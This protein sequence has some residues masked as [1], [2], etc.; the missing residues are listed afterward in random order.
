MPRTAKKVDDLAEDGEH[1]M[2]ALSSVLEI[3][4]EKGVVTW[5]DV[6]E[7][8]TTGEWSRLIEEGLL[9][10]ADGEGFVVDD[11]DGVREAMEDADPASTDDGGV[12]WT[13]YDKGA[14]GIVMMLFVGYVFPE[15][16]AVIGGTIDIAFGPLENM[17]PF[18]LVIMMLALLTGLFSSIMQDNLMDANNMG[19]YKEKSEELKERRKKAK[20]RGD[21]EALEEIQQE[22]MEMMT[23]NVG[24]FTAQ[25]RPMVWIML[26]TIPVFLWLY[27]M[28]LDVGI[29]V[30]SPVLVVPYFGELEAWRQGVAGPMEAWIVW[31]FVCSLGFTQIMRKA[32]NVQTSPTG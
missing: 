14:A 5:S 28:V 12:E 21:D 9:V 1:L 7:E 32:L 13:T 6:S 22:Q 27:W 15:A 4:E 3:A 25:L 20:E 16:R 18:Y 19:D 10:D 30:S 23:E 24:M 26:L 31:Y 29:S 8:L 2:D 11:P 17:M